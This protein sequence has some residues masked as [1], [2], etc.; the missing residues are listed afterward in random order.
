MAKYRANG[1]GRLLVGNGPVRTATDHFKTT[2]VSVPDYADSPFVLRPAEVLPEP[3]PALTGPKHSPLERLRQFW[4]GE[5]DLAPL[6]LF[7]IGYGILLFNWIWQLLPNL[8]QLF[9]DEGMLPRTLLFAGF[10][11]RVNLLAAAGTWWPVFLFWLAGLVVALM[12][13]VGYRTRLACI[14]AFVVVSG[15]EWRNPFILDGSDFVFRLV[16]FWLIF[17]AAGGRYSVDA[18]IRRVRGDPPSGF[19]PA[20]PVRILELQIAWIYLAA[21]IEKT[22]GTTWWDGTAAYYALQLKHTFG[23]AWVEPLVFN[24]IFQRLVSWGTLASELL[25]L[26]LAFSPI[27]HRQARLLA[28]VG[29]AMLHAGIILMMNVGNFPTIMLATLI[30]FLPAPFV[31]RLVDRGRR[32][33]PRSQVRLYYDGACSFCRR[34]AVVLGALDIYRTVTPIDFR[35]VDPSKAGLG[36]LALEKRIHAVD[37]RGRI[38]HGVAAVARASRAIPLLFPLALVLS[39]PGLSCLAQR[40]YDWVAE[41]RLL[42][43]TCPGGPCAFHPDEP[44]SKVRLRSGARFRWRL[45]GYGMLVVVAACAFLTALPSWTAVYRTSD[46]LYRVLFFVGI[47]QSWGMFSPDPARSDGW[48]LAPARLADGTEFDLLTGGPRSDE[49][50]YADPMFSRWVKIF[51]RLVNASYADYRV[52]YGRMHCRLRNWYL[53]PGESPLATFDLYYIERIIPP[54]GQGESILRTHH[55]WAH[56][57]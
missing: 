15:F 55:I 48:V 31:R 9:T 10:P 27:L 24:P 32:L 16:P 39:V 1:A 6:G 54:Q 30:P 19:G 49:P 4:L 29:A 57:C 50:R 44:P 52:E 25:F 51:E 37:E 46:P 20:L 23:R 7:R 5:A 35:A 45:A 8:A 33:F 13:T 11:G 17:T 56:T 41:R 53:R 42:L 36:A 3:K 14:L 43:L 28:I 22:A 21:G 18:A 34:T 40:L 26:A 38:T 12:L 2:D 47:D